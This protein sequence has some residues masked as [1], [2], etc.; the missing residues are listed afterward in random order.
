MNPYTFHNKPV[1]QTLYQALRDDPFYITMEHSVTAA[2]P[3]E[4][5]LK[6][7]DYSMQEGECFG[8]LFL[9]AE[10]SH[11]AS[12]WSKPL[13]GAAAREMKKRKKQFLQEQLGAQSLETYTAIVDYMAEQAAPLIGEEDWYLSIVGVSPTL[14]GRGIGPGLINRVLEKTDCLGANTFLETFT[15]RTISF[16]ERL[17]FVVAGEFLEPTTQAGYAL[18]IR[19][20]QPGE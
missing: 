10:Q 15:P 3:E 12:I 4:G 2:S 20:A 18:M 11:G 14:Q 7:M 1:A 5:M 16:Y 8:E 6:Y 9:P 17:G 13:D 19:E